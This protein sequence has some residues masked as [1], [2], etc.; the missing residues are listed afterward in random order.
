L[1]NTR[2]HGLAILL[3]LAVSIEASMPS[4]LSQPS[5]SYTV[6]VSI[7]NPRITKLWDSRANLTFTISGLGD[8]LNATVQVHSD[9][10][11]LFLNTFYLHGFY[12]G[13]DGLVYQWLDEYPRANSEG[14]AATAQY[15]FR[16]INCEWVDYDVCAKYSMYSS[17]IKITGSLILDSSVIDPGPY[18]ARVTFVAH[19]IVTDY[20]F[21]NSLSYQVLDCWQAYF[22]LPWAILVA[23]LFIAI[24]VLKLRRSRKQ[25]V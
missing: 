1:S 22:W 14:M 7:S 24:A 23:A 6:D 15:S 13:T 16:G 5:L 4:T 2:M 3:L 21:N 11:N 17:A 10:A 8:F 18:Y 19:T 12:L 20:N 25:V 9:A